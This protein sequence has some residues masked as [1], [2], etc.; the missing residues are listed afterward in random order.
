MDRNV[1]RI[2]E[3]QMLREAMRK[4]NA[5]QTS[6][7]DVR[8]NLDICIEMARL[9]ARLRAITFKSDTD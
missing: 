3:K 2:N 7:S 6:T 5:E 9:K 4:L 1:V 8:R